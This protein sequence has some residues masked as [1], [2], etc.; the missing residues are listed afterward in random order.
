ME[1]AP[2][3]S[4]LTRRDR[5][6]ARWTKILLTVLVAAA[7][8]MAVSLVPVGYVIQDAGP[9]VDV[10]GSQGDTPV[11]EFAQ[12]GD[13]DEYVV[14]EGSADDGQLRMVTVSSLGGPGTTV[15]VSDVVRAWFNP[16]A[17]VIPYSD[18]YAP[19]TTAEDVAKAG[20]VQMESSHSASAIAAMDYL[21]VPMETT[22]TVAGTVPGSGA[23]GQLLEGDILVSLKTPDGVVHEVDSP[24][25][26]FVLMENTPA[27]STVEVT[28]L[29]DGAEKTVE[30]VTAAPQA[31]DDEDE[32]GAETDGSAPQG[33]RMGVYLGADTEMPIDVSIHLERIGGPSA[34]LVFALGIVDQLTPGGITGGESIAA[35]GALD[36]VGNVVPIGG[37]VQ[38]MY[39]AKRDGSQWFLIPE[40]N[41]QEAQGREPSGLRV[42]PVGTLSEGVD[43]VQAIS[44]GAGDSLPTC[45]ADTR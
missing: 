19:E 29:R 3:P 45:G 28:V 13:Y 12:S 33:S 32:G 39:G 42:V 6:V 9:T 1:P 8:V 43:A 20:A 37:V 7:I 18:L 11:L 26:P 21:G 25:V 15:R 31:T 14:R 41:C 36:F 35:T 44:D 4:A 24:S 10:L 16:A 23:D 30:I 40:G 2:S 27:N 5:L 22:M 34:G 38:K 17:A